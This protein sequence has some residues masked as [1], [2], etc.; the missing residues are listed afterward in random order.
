MKR[1][2]AL[3]TTLLFALATAACSG[4]GG[5]GG[6]AATFC[7]DLQQLSDQVLDGDLDDPDQLDEV[8][9]GLLESAPS[10]DLQSVRDVESAVNGGDEG[11]ELQE[12]IDDSF[13]DAADD[14]DIDDPFTP[15]ETTVTT[16]AETTTTSTTA[17][18]TTASTESPTTTGGA[19]GDIEVN[20]REAIPGDIAA[21][22][23]DL[24]QACF[25]G[26]PAACDDLFAGTPVGSVDEAYGDTCGGRINEEEGEG[27]AVACADLMV[28]AVP[29]PGDIVDVANA[30]GCFSGDMIACD[31]LFRAAE[32]GSTDQIYGGLCG[33]RVA[34]T[35][36]FCVDIFGDFAIFL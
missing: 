23:F 11:E 35:T 33:G 30:D 20:A 19:G 31:D 27:F 21:E 8:I 17:P 15:P 4:G 2:A 32:P 26:D 12:V 5:G 3:A 25:D 28:G 9:E 34:A 24:A 29:V 36:A 1:A 6:D 14:C 10:A 7:D 16:E 18:S 22:F 13:G